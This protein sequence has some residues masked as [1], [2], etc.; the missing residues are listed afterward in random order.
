MT[1]EHQTALVNS[2]SKETRAKLDYMQDIEDL[3]EEV[4]FLKESIQSLP[5]DLR[6]QVIR[7]MALYAQHNSFKFAKSSLSAEKK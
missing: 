3:Q 7:Y 5:Y 6:K 1:E 4:K 2:L